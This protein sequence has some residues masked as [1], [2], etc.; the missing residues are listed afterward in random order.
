MRAK[1]VP[2]SALTAIAMETVMNARLTITPWEVKPHV[3]KTDKV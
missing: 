1:N 2:V 3:K